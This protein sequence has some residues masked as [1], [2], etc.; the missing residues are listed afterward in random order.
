MLGVSADGQCSPKHR[1][2]SSIVDGSNLFG[3]SISVGTTRLRVRRQNSM[4]ER[5]RQARS[6]LLARFR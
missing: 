3:Q 2:N 6:E 4:V 5:G 1:D